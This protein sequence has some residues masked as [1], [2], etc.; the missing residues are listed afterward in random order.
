MYISTWAAACFIGMVAI[1]FIFII[2]RINDEVS[3]GA[4]T[5]NHGNSVQQQ[6]G[7]KHSVSPHHHPPGWIEDM[8]KKAAVAAHESTQ[9]AVSHMTKSE[10]MVLCFLY[11]AFAW[12]MS[13]GIVLNPRLLL[14]AHSH[15]DG[16]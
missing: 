11:T 4:N 16:C 10:A 5:G 13:N 9:T 2:Q 7:L 15:H 1:A 3:M 12:M 8:Q 14:I 6:Q